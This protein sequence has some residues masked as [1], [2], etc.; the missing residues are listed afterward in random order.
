MHFIC[1]ICGIVTGNEFTG[2]TT[3]AL[4]WKNGASTPLTEDGAANGV[5]VSGTDVYITGSDGVNAVYWKNGVETKLGIGG[6]GNAIF[7]K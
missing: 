4:Y 3:K 7:V 1:V 2:T 6:A 5:M